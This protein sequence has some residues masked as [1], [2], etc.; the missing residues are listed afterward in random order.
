MK[1]IDTREARLR[2]DTYIEE[3]ARRPHPVRIV[4]KGGC[5]HQRCAA[6]G[7]KLV[8]FG[9][10][11]TYLTHYVTTLGRTIYVPDDFDTWS[12]TRAWQ[13]LRHELVHVAQFERY[14]W[15]LMILLYGVLPLP[16][17]LSWFRARFE[18]EAYAETL[19]AVAESEGMDVARSI[20]LREE[21]VRRFTGPDY[22]WMWPFP[23]MVRRWIAEALARIE[24]EGVAVK[25]EPSA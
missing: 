25:A 18:M 14:G 8:T 16:L 21:I 4:R 17:G 19:R 10:Q 11:R 20:E 1:A 13:I 23:G 6:A 2:L 9:G 24:R 15:G 3:L 12:P 7:L 22:A 5:W